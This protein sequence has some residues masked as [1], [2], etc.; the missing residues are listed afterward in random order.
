MVVDGYAY[1]LMVGTY[2]H[3]HI[4]D[5]AWVEQNKLLWGARRIASER[6]ENTGFWFGITSDGV[7]GHGS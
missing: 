2:V 6:M 7:Y 1:S 5:M 3:I 4:D